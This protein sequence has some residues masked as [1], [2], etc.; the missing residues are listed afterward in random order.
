MS[1]DIPTIVLTLFNFLILVLVLG[2][3]LFK[4]VNEIIDSRQNEII[5]SIEKAKIDVEKAELLKIENE[6]KLKE[7]INS[8]KSIVED[9]KKKAEKVE[10]DIIKE[11]NAEAQVIIDRAKKEAEREKLKAQHEIKAQIIDLA[12]LLSSKAIEEAVDEAKHKKLIDD[13]ITKAGI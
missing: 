8:G 13:F 6:K 12:L 10:S 7:T 1:F 9:Y 4:P 5:N 2:K 3:I 11:A